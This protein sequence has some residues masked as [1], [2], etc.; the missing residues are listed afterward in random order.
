MRAQ[1]HPET[2]SHSL[3][4]A[5]SKIRKV[6]KLCSHDLKGPI[7]IIKTGSR[8]AQSGKLGEIPV[9]PL[10]LLKMIETNADQT[11][12]LIEELLAIATGGQAL[13][14]LELEPVPAAALFW[15]EL[16]RQA[17][18]H[19]VKGIRLAAPQAPESEAPVIR[20]D[21]VK[22]IDFVE[23]LLGTLF[24]RCASGGRLAVEVS[25]MRGRRR[26]DVGDLLRIDVREADTQLPASA[27]PALFDDDARLTFCREICQLHGGNLVVR[28][29]AA[30]GLV[31]S[32]YFPHVV[33]PTAMEA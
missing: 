17:E 7:G 16:T 23:S 2:S 24:E 4:L 20:A 22:F 32:V 5:S 6:R 11:L 25:T 1:H 10:K 33:K 28:S 14:A 12:A 9:E 3:I 30:E 26:T 8:L 18:R 15:A 21:R 19:A 13:V 31:W 27:L 29:D